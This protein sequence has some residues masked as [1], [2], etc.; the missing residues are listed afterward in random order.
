M[1]PSVAAMPKPIAPKDLSDAAL[2]LIAS[3]FKVLSEVLRLKLI[4]QLETGEKNVS[5][6]VAATGATQANVSRHL[7]SLTE[8]GIV[9]RRKM[10]Q[11]AF[12]HIC[13]EGVFAM[14]HHV[15]GSLKRRFEAQAKAT[16]FLE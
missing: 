11:K 3:R 1:I 15:C 4:I 2:G 5:A 12:Y 6:L 9:S 14:C 7:Q 8:A 16:R 13:D 10:G